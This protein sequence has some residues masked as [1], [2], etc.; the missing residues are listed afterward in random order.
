MALPEQA[1][2]TRQRRTTD[3]T[4][5]SGTDDTPLSEWAPARTLDIFLRENADGL[6][7]PLD[8]FTADAFAAIAACGSSAQF[9]EAIPKLKA[10]GFASVLGIL[11]AH[12]LP[13]AAGHLALTMLLYYCASGLVLP[14][15]CVDAMSKALATLPSRPE[16]CKL[17]ESTFAGL[18]RQ[19]TP[20][21][22]A[23]A[24][25]INRATVNRH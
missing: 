20:I 25:W 13:T 18:A 24:D 15:C 2:A 23:F 14:D 12:Q 4:S 3:S 19:A 6:Q 1:S 7:E 16:D 10:T 21:R 11:L 22:E 9:H 17:V 5:D 8:P